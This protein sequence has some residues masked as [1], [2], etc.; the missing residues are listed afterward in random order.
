M[1]IKGRPVH[2]RSYVQIALFLVAIAAIGVAVRVV[3]ATA[4][5]FTLPAVTTAAPD[6][7]DPDVVSCERTLP[8]APDPDSE[9][10]LDPIGRITSTSVVECPDAFDGQPVTYVGE[11][12]GDVLTRDGGAWALVNDDAYAL[13]VG[14]LQGHSQYRGSNTGLSVWLPAPVPDVEP[15]GPDRRGT[16]LRI[17]GIVLRADP[18]DGGGLTLRA[19]PGGVEVLDTARTLERPLNRGQALL[20]AVLTVA[21]VATVAAERRAAGRR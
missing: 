17:H 11:L 1:I 2:P 20:A 6:P 21:A 10:P 9:T 4:P 7:D 16:L 8:S 5:E 18:D 12:V 15:G 14:P 13:E 19:F 3:R